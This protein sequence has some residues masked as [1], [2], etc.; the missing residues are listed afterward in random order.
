MDLTEL[1]SSGRNAASNDRPGR[2][3]LC[4]RCGVNCYLP[5]GERRE[6]AAPLQPARPATSRRDGSPIC[7]DCGAMEAI[8]E[9]AGALA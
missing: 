8:L 5:V 1:R 9:L 7:T 3:P 6:P 4:P 2:Y